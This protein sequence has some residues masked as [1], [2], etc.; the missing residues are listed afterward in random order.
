MGRR[1]CCGC[2]HRAAAA[3]AAVHRGLAAVGRYRRR[4]RARRAAAATAAAAAAAL[5]PTGRAYCTQVRA[6]HSAQLRILHTPLLRPDRSRSGTRRRCQRIATDD[7]SVAK[8]GGSLARRYLWCSVRVGRRQ[9]IHLARCGADQYHSSGWSSAAWS[10]PQPSYRPP[11]TCRDSRIRRTSRWKAAPYGS[12]LSQLDV[13]DS[14][15]LSI[16]R[17]CARTVFACWRRSRPRMRSTGRV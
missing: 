10:R 2:A 12:S 1:Y 4:C 9:E 17:S 6:S 11:A 5:T 16:P 13:F 8:R 14:I 15:V 7:S 3:V